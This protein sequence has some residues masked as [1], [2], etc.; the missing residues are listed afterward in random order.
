M[1]QSSC[2]GKWRSNENGEGSGKGPWRHCWKEIA[3]EQKGNRDDDGHFATP[4]L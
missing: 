4:G 3:L 2:G 1:R